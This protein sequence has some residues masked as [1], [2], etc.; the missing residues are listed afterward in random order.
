MSRELICSVLGLPIETWP[1][2]HYTLIGLR[3]DQ[4][5][6]ARIESR[7]QELSARL[8]PF[9][10]AHPDEVTDTLNRLARALVCLSDP[11]ARAAYDKS[12][13]L[14]TTAPSKTP[15]QLADELVALPNT[16]RTPEIPPSETVVDAQRSARR[17]TYRRLALLRRWHSAWIEIGRWYGQPN[18]RLADLLEATELIRAAWSL[19][20]QA[21]LAL[22]IDFRPG[23]GAEVIALVRAPHALNAFRRMTS[24]Q[25]ESLA[26]DW[27][28]GLAL[29]D[30][31]LSRLRG[32][33]QRR[34]AVPRS[35]VRIARYLVTEGLD[36]TL[37]VLGLVAL[38]VALARNRN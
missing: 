25:R 5:D 31:E 12:R 4:A 1:P 8:R 36:I 30:R 37:F 15:F 3:P 7:V 9:Q 21:A 23:S 18:R 28:A 2:D 34:R 35:V 27:R 14:T 13:S 24:S 29:L 32:H 20:N 16:V 33:V 22:A 38:G 11:H 10:L 26:V 17:M 6:P 19:R